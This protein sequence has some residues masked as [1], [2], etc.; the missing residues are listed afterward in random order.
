MAAGARLVVLHYVTPLISPDRFT[1]YDSRFTRC[2]H[3]SGTGD[4]EVKI[5]GDLECW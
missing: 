4:V 3:D 1:I 5:K 2:A